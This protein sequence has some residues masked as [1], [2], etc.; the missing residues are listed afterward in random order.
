MNHHF[1]GE[2]RNTSVGAGD[3]GQVRE[4]AEAPPLPVIQ[5][6]RP[7][8][9]LN[10]RIKQGRDGDENMVYSISG[11]PIRKKVYRMESDIFGT[12]MNPILGGGGRQSWPSAQAPE[13]G[14][15][16]GTGPAHFDQDGVGSGRRGGMFG[17]D[18]DGSNNLQDP[19]KMAAAGKP[20]PSRSDNVRRILFWVHSST[21]GM[22]NSEIVLICSGTLYW[23]R[24]NEN[25]LKLR[26][27]FLSGMLE[28]TEGTLL[29]EKDMLR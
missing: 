9:L 23:M 18:R 12:G 13:H 24:M 22:H 8:Q 27:A 10:G 26:L 28:R 15:R 5:G 6:N 19:V 1:H 29:R 16:N 4:E 20:T 3:P 2:A 25:D 21:S 14:E 17:R 7:V 11:L